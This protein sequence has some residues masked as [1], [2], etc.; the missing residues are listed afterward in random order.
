MRRIIDF[1][2]DHRLV[3]FLVTLLLI[4]WGLVHAPFNWDIPLIPSDPVSVDAIPDLGENQQIVFTEWP[5]RSPRDVEDQITYPLTTVLMGVPG[6]KSVRSSSMFGFSSIYI[7]FEEDVDFYW[8]R[9]RILEKLNSIPAN[10]LPEGVSPSLGPDATALGQVFWYTLQGMDSTGNPIGGWNLDELRSIQDYYVKYALTSVEGVSEVASVGGFVKEYQIDLDPAKMERYGVTLKNV[11]NSVRNTNRDAGAQTLEINQV[12]Y[13]IRGIG[14]LKN[15]NDLRSTVV[16]YQNGVGITL[17]QVAHIHTGPA[18]RR[19]ILDLNGYE[20]VGGVVVARYGANPMKVIQKT[21]DKIKEISSSLPEKTLENGSTSKVSIVPFYDR[22]ELIEETVHTLEE[23][24]TLE[25]FITVIVVVLLVLNLRAAILIASLLPISILMVFIAMKY[26][27]VEA[28]IVALSGIAIAIGTMVDLGIILTENIIAHRGDH[29]DQSIV[30]TVKN[31]THEVSGAILTAVLTTIVSFI[32]VFTLQAAE[33]KLFGPLA[34]TKTAALIAALLVSIVLLPAFAAVVFKKHKNRQSYKTAIRFFLL[35]IGVIAV[36]NGVFLGGVLVV[37][38]LSLLVRNRF[39]KNTYLQKSPLY[40]IALGSAVALALYWLPLGPGTAKVGQVAFVIITLGLIIGVFY[41]VKKYYAHVLN[42]FLNHKKAFLAV[43]SVAIL[44]AC[45]VWL[46]FAR[47]TQPLQNL[48]HQLNWNIQDTWVWTKMDQTF[49]GI[50]SEFMPSL[51][52]GS[53]LLMPTSL[54]HSGVE[55]N[56]KALAELD[57]RVNA[58]PEIERVVG[59][60]GRVE[61]ALDP[62]PLSMFENVI[63]YYPEYAEDD[64]GNRIRFASDQDGRLITKSNDTI[65][66][67][68]VRERKHLW[69]ELKR[70]EDGVI[71]RH[72]RPHIKTRDD[73]W[74][75]IAAATQMPGVT[76]A[77]KLQPI[78]TRLVMLQTGMRAP[79]GIKVFGDDINTLEDFGQD[80]AQILQSTPGIKT[81]AVYAERTIGKPYM[82][83]KID[84]KKIAEYGL[85]IED[86]QQVIET[87]IGGK[88]VTQTVEKRERYAVRIRYPIELR[89]HPEEIQNIRVDIPNGRTIPLSEVM[90]IQFQNGP[91][92]LK[93]ENTF[94]VSYVLFDKTDDVSAGAAVDLA[95]NAISK[96]TQEGDLIV[97]AGVSFEFSGNYENQIRAE[98]RLS[99]VIPI[100]LVIV[101][102]ILYLQFKSVSTSLMIFTGIA[103]AF[104]GAFL[105]IWLYNQNGFLDFSIAGESLREVFQISQINTSV[106]V[107]VGFIALFGIATDDGVLMSTYLVQS[108][109]RNKPKSIEEIR[110]AVITGSQRRIRP[111]VMTSATTLIALLPIMTSTG[112]GSDIMIPMAIPAFGGMLF[113]IISYFVVPV[114]YSWR[115]EFNYRKNIKS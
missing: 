56:R 99:M 36:V 14:Y 20:V 21:K 102:L 92:S 51:D 57:L 42:F 91:Q 16:K 60:A 89:N 53:F 88:T 90:D 105:W 12:E 72:W 28:N 29:P 76:A 26:S 108:F 38:A 112:K 46:G 69:I 84:R 68:R 27:G 113:S 94:P 97:P 6:V 110:S 1:F 55:F 114:L 31:A 7:I 80:L 40:I 85:S 115:E 24:L 11:L 100:V 64:D 95:K 44:L 33:G 50:G 111:A 19:G 9:S 25:V 10:T 30:K 49:P 79:M 4:I 54:P 77:P 104:S 15:L 93:S 39:P 58:I 8:S 18:Q 86:V 66:A 74:N 71:F 22:S 81:S 43:P 83:L 78:E 37:Y 109:E 75:E 48:A 61:S 35:L 73:I 106:A 45:T 107:W 3:T 82:E 32:P 47:I 62:A 101:F 5:G 96:A 41:I 65:T 2:I 13:F 98:K 70:D 63:L 67:D 17:E 34:F 103:V 52:E 87:T 59:K 23:A